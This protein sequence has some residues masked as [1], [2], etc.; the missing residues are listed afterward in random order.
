M[1]E[2][3][4]RKKS[5]S[6]LEIAK[7]NASIDLLYTLE[8]EKIVEDYVAYQE[9]LMKKENEIRYPFGPVERIKDNQSILQ[10]NNSDE[11]N[12]TKIMVETLR[13]FYQEKPNYVENKVDGS[14]YEV[15]IEYSGISQVNL[16]SYLCR[17]RKGNWKR[18]HFERG[19]EISIHRYDSKIANE[20][21][22]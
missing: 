7:K 21:I 17:K 11:R 14:F 1:E 12:P 15:I 2:A 22:L 13:K 5:P 6:T 4:V 10:I 16:L 9:E 8:R 20:I 19:K 18:N 3:N